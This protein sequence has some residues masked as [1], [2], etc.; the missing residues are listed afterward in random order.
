[1]PPA[2]K[3]NVC[4]T[5][6]DLKSSNRGHLLEGL[7]KFATHKFLNTKDQ[8]SLFLTNCSETSNSK[9]VDNVLRTRIDEFQVNEIFD[10]IN[11]AKPST[12]DPVNLLDILSLAIHYVKQARGMPGV[13]TLQIVYFT[14]LSSQVVKSDDRQI[15]KIIGDLNDDEIYLFIIGPDVAVPT[16]ITNFDDIPKCMKGIMVVSVVV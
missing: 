6:F 12:G 14:D 10:C 2:P 5:L 7:I 3:R 13:I 15:A 11:E 16:P 8:C 9:N 4:L 1:M